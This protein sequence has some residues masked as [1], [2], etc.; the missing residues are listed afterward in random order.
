MFF[1]F[2]IFCCFK[3]ILLDILINYFDCSQS[4]ALDFKNS[5]VKNNTIWIT[6]LTSLGEIWTGPGVDLAE[7]GW[8]MGLTQ[9]NGLD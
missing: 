9:Q 4:N 5:W 1:Y 6:L 2:V 7:Q 8:V 3:L